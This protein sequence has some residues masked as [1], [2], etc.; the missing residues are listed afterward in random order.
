MNRR[1]EAQRAFRCAAYLIRQRAAGA[2]VEA[3]ARRQAGCPDAG[4]PAAPLSVLAGAGKAQDP[5][6]RVAPDLAMGVLK[7]D[8]R[9]VRSVVDSLT[10][11]SSDPEVQP[12][13]I[14]ARYDLALLLAGSRGGWDEASAIWEDLARTGHA[15]SRL[16]LAEAWTRRARRTN[17]R[18]ARSNLLAR[19]KAQYE[20]L[21]V[22]Q[23]ANAE[24]KRRLAQIERE[25]LPR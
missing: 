11:L 14:T 25:T 21:A 18:A 6:R 12:F 9:L 13:L 24:L 1:A 20:I 15:P 2:V 7:K 23:P 10:G 5:V 19:A 4:S 22:E 16:A 3:A 17:D 8:V